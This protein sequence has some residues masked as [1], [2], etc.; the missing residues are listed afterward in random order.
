MELKIFWKKDCPNCP[1][2]KKIGKFMEDK[3]N[4]EVQYCDIDTV[5]GLSEACMFKVMSTPSLILID[6]DNN[7]IQAWRGV[8]PTIENI[9]EK[10]SE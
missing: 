1:E 3:D 7:E 2:A 4:V 9:K 10:I 6:K 8:I 5:E